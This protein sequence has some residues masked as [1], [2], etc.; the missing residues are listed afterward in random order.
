[1]PILK[2]LFYLSENFN[3]LFFAAG[4]LTILNNNKHQSRKSINATKLYKEFSYVKL[5]FV[6]LSRKLTN[7]LQF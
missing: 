6:A 1:M 7:R 2:M 3:N 4:I 5:Y